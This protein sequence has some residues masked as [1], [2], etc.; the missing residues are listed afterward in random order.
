MGVTETHWKVGLNESLY[1]CI[2]LALIPAFGGAESRQSALDG[3]RGGGA[4]LTLRQ[5]DTLTAEQLD[6]G[7]GDGGEIGSESS[8]DLN[9][10]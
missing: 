1:D 9:R 8:C 3:I 7:G 10:G 5:A 4:Y 6:G 2:S